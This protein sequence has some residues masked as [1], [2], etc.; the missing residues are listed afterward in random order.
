MF[1]MD[2]VPSYPSF[3]LICG[4][5]LFISAECMPLVSVAVNN[6]SFHG[7]ILSNNNVVALRSRPDIGMCEIMFKVTSISFEVDGTTR[8]DLNNLS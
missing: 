7:F 2:Q 4:H 3:H 1:A 6:Y 8:Y 5:H